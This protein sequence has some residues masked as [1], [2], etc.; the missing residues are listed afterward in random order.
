MST[1]PIAILADSHD[2]VATVRAALALL[3]PYAP[4]LYLHCGDMVNPRVLE[5]FIDLPFHFVQG[6]NDDPDALRSYAAILGLTFHGACA[7]LTHAGKRIALLHGDDTAL[8][9]RLI[10]QQQFD[11]LLHGHTHVRADQQIGKT[12]IV[13]PG[14]LQRARE[15]SVALLWVEENRLQ[16][17]P[18]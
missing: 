1:S 12:R 2:N 18:V 7:D 9:H 15:K 13:N 10:K 6:N 3:S 8:Y 5:E 4:V 17:V 16:F 11:Y 14:A